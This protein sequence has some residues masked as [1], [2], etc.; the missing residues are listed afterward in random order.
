MTWE[1]RGEDAEK[2]FDTMEGLIAWLK[3]TGRGKDIRHWYVRECFDTDDLL[4]S[5]ADGRFEGITADDIL[6][7]ALCEIRFSERSILGVRFAEE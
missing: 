4:T 1:Y 2:R 6:E 3:E 7:D 5:V